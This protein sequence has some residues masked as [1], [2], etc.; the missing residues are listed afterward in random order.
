MQLKRNCFLIFII[1]M[2]LMI[3]SCSKGRSDLNIEIA[4]PDKGLVD[5]ASKIYNESELLEITRFDGS[6]KE[7]NNKYPIACLRE[8]NGI[9]RA[10]YLG[11]GSI[12]IFLFDGSG[13]KLSAKTYS[14][15][16]FKSDFDGLTKG[17]SLDEVR[18]IDPNGEYLFL[19]T[20]RNDIPR[21][22]SHYTKDGYCITI[23]YDA[24][25][26]ITSINKELI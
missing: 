4:P 20:G 25:N 2:L 19:F 17:Q 12:G 22:S 7:L 10:A 6:L 15:Q 14:M 3:C 26:A 24:L 8:D 5:L 23:A 1:V 16:R 11:D 13:N 18:A 9:Y 21:V